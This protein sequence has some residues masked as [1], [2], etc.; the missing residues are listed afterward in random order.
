MTRLGSNPAR[1]K[2]SS[3]QPARVTAVVLSYVPHLDGYFSQ[4][5]DVLRLTISSLLHHAETPLDLLV[6]DNGSCDPV[7]AYLQE[8]NRTGAIQY[9]L[10]SKENIGNVG[11]LKIAFQSA[12]GEVIAYC[13]DD[14]YFYPNWLK[15]QLEILKRFPRVGLVSGVPVRDAA[16]HAVQALKDV[17]S[18]QEEIHVNYERAIPDVWERDWAISTGRDADKHLMATREHQ[19]MVLEI[20]EHRAIGAANHFQFLGYKNVLLDALP[21]EWPG[22]LMWDMVQLDEAI[23]SNGLLR[24]STTGRFCQHIGNAISADLTE[25]ARAAG[26][27]VDVAHALPKR[28]R[29]W[30]QKIP[31][32]GRIIRWIYD[33]LFRILNDIDLG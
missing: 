26:L 12:P 31:G 27:S 9:L 3:Y 10:Q 1:G 22:K 24:L 4:R 30:L 13:D 32:S 18:E 29:H 19:D 14:V 23:D 20:G 6:F 25:E 15:P 8:L 16:R 17:A 28:R 2:S 5:F 21:S 11:A 33:R 7:K